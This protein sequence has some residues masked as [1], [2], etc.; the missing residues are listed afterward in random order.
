MQD[1]QR[2]SGPTLA[3]GR[4]VCIVKPL[5]ITSR[6]AN[7][8]RCASLSDLSDAPSWTFDN[9]DEL[10]G[11]AHGSFRPSA[12]YPTEHSYI[13]LV[14]ARDIHATQLDKCIISIGGAWTGDRNLD[15][16]KR[17]SLPFLDVEIP[18]ILPINVS[19]RRTPLGRK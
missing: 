6:G 4:F 1:Q 16:F 17:G 18:V 7:V 3:R 8:F 12:P 13:V 19:F 9:H 5:S 15:C 2:D 14:F 11:I 10:L